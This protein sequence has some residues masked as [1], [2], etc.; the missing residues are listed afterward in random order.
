MTLS[1]EVQVVTDAPH[2]P[3]GD[4]LAQWARAAARTGGGAEGELTI[5][6]VDE[7]ECQALNL[8]YRGKDRPTNVLSFPF[9]M[10][11]GL[12]VEA[13]EPVL[14]DLVICAPVVNREAGEQGKQTEAH[15]AH[16]VTHG[17]LHLLQ[18]D[19]IEDDDAARMEDLE[20][21]ILTSQG[22][23]DPWQEQT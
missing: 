5:R 1:V 22:F 23:P 8:D 13:S 19:H 12:P 15:W 2:V 10:P 16:M 21:R 17:V 18:Y 3:S 6:I 11:P 9:D 14:G 7:E 20:S 4:Q